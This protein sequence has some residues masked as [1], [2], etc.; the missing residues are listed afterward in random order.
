[1]RGRAK[2][3]PHGPTMRERKGG[4]ARGWIS[5]LNEKQASAVIDALEAEGTGGKGARAGMGLAREENRSL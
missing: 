3:L 4:D 1:M 5:R 2:H